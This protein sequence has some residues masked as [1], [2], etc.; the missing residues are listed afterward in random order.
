MYLVLIC[1]STG[2]AVP[3]DLQAY[4]YK[5]DGSIQS[6]SFSFLGRLCGKHLP[7]KPEWPTLSHVVLR[8]D[9]FALGV[10]KN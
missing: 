10:I 2:E 5:D 8:A 9:T 4:A 7:K 6:M 3:S 1:D